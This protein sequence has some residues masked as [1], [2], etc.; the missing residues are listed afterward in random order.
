[1][2]ARV[3]ARQMRAPR[4]A[5]C[6]SRVAPPPPPPSHYCSQPEFVEAVGLTRPEVL[7]KFIRGGFSR[8]ERWK[9]ETHR[10]NEWRRRLRVVA[11]A[12]GPA[13]V[14]LAGRR[15]TWEAA[16]EIGRGKVR[17]VKFEF[18]EDKKMKL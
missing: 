12:L 2:F 1:M 5:I 9:R 17:G 8:E 18:F 11:L 14:V 6:V 16:R 15:G 7:E 13:G 4:C 10:A 3:P